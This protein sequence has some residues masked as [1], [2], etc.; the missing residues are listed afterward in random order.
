MLCATTKNMAV[1]DQEFLKVLESLNILV[2]LENREYK[3]DRKS[4][5]KIQLEPN[6]K[7][8]GNM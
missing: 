1:E 6:N 2:K 3:L 5:Y 8:G 4:I 7:I